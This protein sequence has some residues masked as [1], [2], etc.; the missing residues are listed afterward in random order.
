MLGD[1]VLKPFK[2]LPW[3]T[4]WTGQFDVLSLTPPKAEVP[5]AWRAPH[6]SGFD[7]NAVDCYISANKHATKIL[8]ASGAHT[9]RAGLN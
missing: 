5:K 9:Q 3:Q 4:S 2:L 1:A 7:Q 8:W 6:F